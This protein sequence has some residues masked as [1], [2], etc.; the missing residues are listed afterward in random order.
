MRPMWG[1]WHL[2]NPNENIGPYSNLK[3]YDLAK[4]DESAL[5]KLRVVMRLLHNIAVHLELLSR[6]QL[7][8]CLSVEDRDNVYEKSWSF[9]MVGRSSERSLKYMT[10]YK[11]LAEKKLNV[12][13][14]IGGV[15]PVDNN[16]F[17]I[18]GED[19][20]MEIDM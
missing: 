4:R 13:A 9:L 12:P 20:D 1:L 5:S 16:E 7:I 6:N 14:D 15:A 3:K 10:V 19:M 2:G 8:K 11:L 18:N 17:V